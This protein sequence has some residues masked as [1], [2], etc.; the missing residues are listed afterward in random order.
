MQSAPISGIETVNGLY[1]IP[2]NVNEVITPEIYGA[3]G[4][5]V[6]DDSVPLQKALDCCFK[7]PTNFIFKGTRYKNYG[8]G[9]PIDIDMSKVPNSDGLVDFNGAKITAIADKMQYVLSYK[10]T[11]MENG[12]YIHHAKRL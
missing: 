10:T 11:G 6:T 3:K 9:T 7:N 12:S 5:G 8:V 4:D 1:L 2:T